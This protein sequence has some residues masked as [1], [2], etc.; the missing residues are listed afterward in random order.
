MMRRFLWLPALAGLA[1]LTGCP[2]DPYKAETWTKKLG[3]Q[4]ASERAVTELEHLG[5]PVAIDDLGKAWVDQGKPARLLQVII[6]LARPLTPEQAERDN[7]T[8]YA[9]TGRPASWGAALPYLKQALTGVDEANRASVESASQAADALGEARQAEGLDALIELAT[10]PVT[11]KLLPA[12]IAALRAIGKYSSAGDRA[13]AALAKIIDREPPP[14][15][16]SAKDREQSRALAD[17]YN[18]FLAVTGAAINGLGELHVASAAKPLVLSM[19]RT[20]ELFTQIRRALVATGPAAFDELRRALAG[21]HPAV[22]QLFKDKRLDRY[23][24]DRND[25]PPDQCQRV[26]A[27]VFYPAVVL[28]DFYDPRAVPE[29]VGALQSP[30]SPVYYVDDQPSPNTQYNAL[31]DALRKIGAADA[32]ATVRG[33]WMGQSAAPPPRAARGGKRGAEPAKP[34][35]ESDLST[36]IL[37][38]GAYP[39]VTRDDAGVEELGKIA[40]DNNA[41][42]SLRQEAA[43]AFARLARDPRDIAI[44]QGLAQKY[45]EASTKKRAEADG[46]AKATADAADREFAKAKKLLDD[47]K[48]NVLKTSHDSS[49]SAEDIRGATDAAKKAEDVFK[50][51]KKAHAEAVAPYRSADAAAKGYKGYARMF[52]SHIARIEVAIRCKQDIN[53]YAASLKLKPADAARNNAPYIRD[54][55]DWTADEQVGLVDGAIERSM[56]ELG[57]AGRKAASQTD[58]LLEHAKSDDRII[59]QSVLLALPKIAAVPCANCETKL[60]EAIRTGEGKTTLGDLNLETTMVKNYFAWA[61]GKTPTTAGD[62]DDL[63]SAAPSGRKK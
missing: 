35:G 23:C 55:K 26:S 40:S 48:A 1:V 47:A 12:Q 57:K 8:D 41:D 25:A 14:S 21:T 27:M 10:K 52:Q 6:S 20:P 15:P 13:S 62:K 63:P 39:F 59:R 50:L 17:K 53:C 31:F 16:R 3:D 49:K 44:L 56:I 37:A 42:A 60:A 38:I 45:F 36:R 2:D 32:A 9:K 34:S 18:Q 30:P 24:G 51:A 61:G 28:G 11:G 43:T 7:F 46:K 19:Y 58:L 33:M 4:G 54:I 29:L 5:N 22:N